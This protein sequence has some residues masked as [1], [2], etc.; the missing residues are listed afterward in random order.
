MVLSLLVPGEA[1]VELEP[2]ELDELEEPL[3]DELELEL[4]DELELDGCT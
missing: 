1:G 3:L 2:E 4:P